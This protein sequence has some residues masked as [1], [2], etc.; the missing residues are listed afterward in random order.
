MPEETNRHPHHVN[1]I[2][3]RDPAC[4]GYS[5]ASLTNTTQG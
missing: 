5:G 2:N 4:Y 3:I 1:E